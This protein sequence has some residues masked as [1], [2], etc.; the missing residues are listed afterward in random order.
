MSYVSARSM[1]CL[2]KRWP[3]KPSAGSMPIVPPLAARKRPHLD[4][5]G[6]ADLLDHQLGDPVASGDGEALPGIG[7][8][9]VDLDLTAVASV[10]SA[11][12]VQHGDA[13][14]GCQTGAWMDER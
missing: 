11:R 1:S 4:E 10:H 14:L 2:S 9:Q 6:R 8:E 5:V 13:V 3:A 7:V 12:R